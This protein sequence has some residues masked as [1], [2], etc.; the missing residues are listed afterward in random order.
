MPVSA[1]K[2]CFYYWWDPATRTKEV[3]EMIIAWVLTILAWLVFLVCEWAGFSPEKWPTLSKPIF[4]KVTFGLAI[5][6]TLR[7]IFWLPF[8][9]HEKLAA[10][11]EAVKPQPPKIKTLVPEQTTGNKSTTGNKFERL[12]EVENA[13]QGKTLVAEP[14]AI[15][16]SQPPKINALAPKQT[17]ANKFARLNEVENTSKGETPVAEPEAIKQTQPP[18][19]K[20][21][22]P[23]QTPANKFARL[24]EVENASK[25]KTLV[26]ELE[27]IKQSQPP[28]IKAP[29][30]EQTPANTFERLNEVENASK[31]KT[32]VAELEAIKQS[33]PPKINALAPKQ[34]PA[35]KFARLNE[36]EAVKQT[37]PP[38]I[39]AL[40]PKQTRGNIF[41]RLLEIKKEIESESAE[42]VDEELWKIDPPPPYA[43]SNSDLPLQL[44]TLPQAKFQ[45][46]LAAEPEAANKPQPLKIKALPAELTTG[47]RFECSIEVENESENQAAENVEVKL[48]EI[49]PIPKY[50]SSKTDLPLHFPILPQA[51]SKTP[52]VINPKNSTRFVLFNVTQTLSEVAF[53]IVGVGHNAKIFSHR[54]W[55]WPP[56]YPFPKGKPP[57]VLEYRITISASSNRH[58]LVKETFKLECPSRWIHEKPFSLTKI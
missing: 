22:A 2:R 33:Q 30:P 29:A 6:L 8:R 38:E 53:E 39:E 58:A 11:L 14:E 20:A 23:E 44:P 42:N 40:P 34:T 19:I 54:F 25:G 16:Q 1:I 3:F 45:N 57:E 55:E 27:A 47:N 10:E 51:K 35:N 5:I 32:L 24:K 4:E 28:K 21:P 12:N 15:K 56:N 50:V 17:P 9:R 46:P 43:S 49:D 18:K 41:E 36:V 37:Q 52:G 48:L 26:A 13:S 31:G 7:A